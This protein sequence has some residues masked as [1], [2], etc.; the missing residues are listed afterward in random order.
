[1]TICRCG[2]LRRRVSVLQ[3]RR[4]N[5]LQVIQEFELQQ[6]ALSVPLP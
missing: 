2:V 4:R 5:P 6:S 1:M 3:I